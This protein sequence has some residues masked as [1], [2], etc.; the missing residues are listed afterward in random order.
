MNQNL[1]DHSGWKWC[2]FEGAEMNALLLGLETSF[3]EKILWM[4]EMQ[5]FHDR[6]AEGR[7]KR[8]REENNANAKA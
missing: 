3:R 7:S 1:A 8:L 6:F 4:E 2:T 5:K